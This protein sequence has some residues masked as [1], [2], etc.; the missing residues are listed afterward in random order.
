[1]AMIVGIDL[2]TT[3]S[4]VALWREGEAQ[5]VPNALGEALTPSVVGLDDSGEVLVGRAARERLLTHPDQTAALFKRYMGTERQVRLGKRDFRPEE[6][7]ALVL[8]SLKD[9]AEAWLGSPVTEAV[10]SVPAYFSDAQRKSTRAAGTMAGLK[11]ERLINEPTAAALAYGLHH[12]ETESKFLVFDLGGGTFDVSVLELF[13]G[14][15]E[16]RASTGD[17]FL[18]GEDFVEQLV[19]GFIEAVGK[20][21]GLAQDGLTGR[22]GAA[23][24][25]EAELAKRHL[26]ERK[27]AEMR[28]RWQ[29]RE[30]TWALDEADFAVCAQDL[31]ARLAA[32]VERALRD[33]QIDP[34]ELDEVLLIGGATRM[35]TVRKLVARL[36]GRLPSSHLDPDRAVALG[37]AVQ[38][39]LKARDAALD[40]VVVTDV[41]PYTLG[42]EVG[43]QIG[44]EQVQEGLY[45][46]LIERNTT[47]PASRVR[48]VYPLSERQKAVDVGVF[49]GESRNVKQNIPLGMLRVALPRGG[50]IDDKAVDVRFTYDIDGLLEVEA[51]VVATGEV[52]SMIVEQA[53]GT[54]SPKEIEKRMKAL[55]KLKIHPRDQSENRALLARAE[56]L[57][58]ER[59]GETRDTIDRLLSRFEQLL[60][61][62]DP[63]RIAEGRLRLA[64]ALDAIEGESYF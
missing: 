18:G 4:L 55:A 58:E 31:M 13:E 7:S 19:Q 15:M 5:V 56:R 11:V 53:P 12:R 33:A 63:E 57:Y 64:E 49:Q 22:L 40:E 52:K 34:K 41:C 3:N 60:A 29:D 61:G 8:T 54:L 2:G 21:A 24:R 20:P 9:D 38:A 25:R 10:I 62:Q 28:V 39:G 48:Q 37:A 44:E 27:A 1:M 51:K 35:P 46:P 23:L 45:L 47:I 6:L 16:V 36:F 50:G 43:R 59:R 17:N 14:I 32:P 30:L 42:V 26:S